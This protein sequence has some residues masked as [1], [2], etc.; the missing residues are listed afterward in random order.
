MT[1]T[2]STKKLQHHVFY[3][4]DLDESLE[5]YTDLFNVQFSA[6]NHPDSSAAMRMMQQTMYFVSFGYYHHDLCFVENRNFTVDNDEMLHMTLMLQDGHS[7]SDLRQKLN[8]RNITPK[9]GRMLASSR[10]I[11]GK[12]AICF[13]DPSGHWLEVIGK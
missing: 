3:V 2:I 9:E 1:D 6:R 7:I 10:P 5:F 4:K 11:E 8:Q 12:E 13:P